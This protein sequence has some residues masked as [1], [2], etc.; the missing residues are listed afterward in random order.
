MKGRDLEWEVPEIELGNVGNWINSQTR[1]RRMPERVIL[2]VLIDLQT[3][4]RGANKE[5]TDYDYEEYL[6]PIH[7]VRL[8]KDM[9]FVRGLSSD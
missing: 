3:P 2:V 9:C 7:V 6:P 1:Q 8:C 5:Y 4:Y